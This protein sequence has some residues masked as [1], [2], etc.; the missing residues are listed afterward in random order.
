MSKKIIFYGPLWHT[1]GR[2]GGSETGN[3]RSVEILTKLGFNIFLLNKPYFP[4]GSLKALAY[5][6]QLLYAYLKFVWQL[7][8]TRVDSFHLSA[9]YFYLIYIECLYIL[10]C[11]LFKVHSVYEIRAGGAEIAYNSKS[12]VYRYVFRLTIKKADIVLC[13][14]IESVNFIKLITGKQALYYPN[15]IMDEQHTPYI[16]N[17]RENTEILELVYFGRIV[18]SKNIEFI[19]E[20]GRRL[21]VNG[22]KFNLEIIGNT[23]GNDA[24]LNKLNGLIDQYEISNQVKLPGAVKPDKLFPLLLGK[25]FFLFPS[26]ESREGHSNSLTEAMSRGVV[27][28]V[29]TAGFNRS[30]VANN[31]LVIEEFDPV[32]YADRITTIWLSGQWKELS[33]NC[34]SIIENS[35]TESAVTNT[36]YKAHSIVQNNNI[37][38]A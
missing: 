1:N 38:V 10:T 28:I 35:F 22:V 31:N 17:N 8:T 5:P 37:S 34:Y 29:S 36:L 12:A 26:M 19:I 14:G 16:S 3:K 21:K 2:I 30:I 13:Q 15:Y 7:L 27:P 6:F 4:G 24:Y 18:P 11:R 33:K 20:I 23:N 9:Y 32:L 25:H